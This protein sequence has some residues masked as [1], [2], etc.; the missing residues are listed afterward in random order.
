MLPL[1][2]KGCADER[3]SWTREPIA[4]RSLDILGKLLLL[5]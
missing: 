3:L 4:T 1:V 5:V 2:L